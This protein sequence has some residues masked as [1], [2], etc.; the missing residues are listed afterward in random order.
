MFQ[1]YVFSFVSVPQ[2][3]KHG[4]NE[5]IIPFDFDAFQADIKGGSPRRVDSRPLQLY[6]L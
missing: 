2:N 4:V 3:P 6:C 1:W 5:I